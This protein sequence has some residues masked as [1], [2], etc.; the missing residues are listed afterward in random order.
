M[1]RRL[2][3]PLVILLAFGLVPEAR[4]QGPL[5]PPTPASQAPAPQGAAP[6]A[7]PTSPVPTSVHWRHDYTKARK[8]AQ[9]KNLPLILDFC[10]QGCVPCKQ[11]DLTTFRDP[12]V[13][14]L[15]H[16]RFVP[17]KVEQEKD[18]T[19]VSALRIHSFPT[20]VLAGPDGKIL[21]TLE[22]F[23]EAPKLLEMLHRVIISTTNPDWMV[24]DYQLALKLTG[25]GEYA[26]AI[27]LLRN[28]LEDG[29]SRPIQGSAQK[30]LADMEYRALERVTHARQ[31]SDRGQ[32]PQAIQML[33]EAIRDFPGLQATREA[34][35]LMARMAQNPE[36]RSHQRLRRAQDLLTQ[37]KEYYKNRDYFLSL[38]RCEAL[39]NGYPDLSE[40][41]EG[42][43][44]ANEIKNNP[45]LLQN[46]CDS[47]SDRLGNLYLSLADSLLKKG[48][49]QQAM[50]YLQRVISAFPG[51][52]QAESAQI[53]LGQLQGTPT[54]R[55]DFQRPLQP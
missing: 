33:S 49:R 11:L 1:R 15:I 34:T 40:G 5:A 4:S 55:V 8:E 25:A 24:R 53:R 6:H 13:L 16:E 3:H 14:Q 19:L 39:V 10:M 23:Q 12:K 22:G 45:D 2:L 37:A 32:T 21:H 26:R 46:A 42:A 27:A 7:P 52:R 28:I 44:L 18:P 17:L 35:D 50:N 54:M 31:F 41:Q 36:I 38:D 47:L 43:Q 29:S 30:L 51:T 20:L 9:D 48:Q